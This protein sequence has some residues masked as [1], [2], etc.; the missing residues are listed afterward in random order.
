MPHLFERLGH[1]NVIV[2]FEGT[3]RGGQARFAQKVIACRQGEQ[4]WKLWKAGFYGDLSLS[5]AVV[6]FARSH[7]EI[8]SAFIPF[9]EHADVRYP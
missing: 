3:K 2:R 5:A 6:R 9:H 7:A 4:A 8:Q 1:S